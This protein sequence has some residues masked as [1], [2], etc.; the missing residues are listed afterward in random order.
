VVIAPS[1]LLGHQH[2]ACAETAATARPPTN[3]TISVRIPPSIR[4]VKHTV[5]RCRLAEL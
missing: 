4:D 5:G 1:A 3:A 2:A